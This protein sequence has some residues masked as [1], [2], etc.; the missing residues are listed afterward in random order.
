MSGKAALPVSSAQGAI[1]IGR[2]SRPLGRRKAIGASIALRR[3]I[4]MRAPRRSDAAPTRKNRS[5]V[6]EDAAAPAAGPFDR[7]QT[8]RATLRLQ[9]PPPPLT[10]GVWNARASLQSR[11]WPQRGR[12][13]R[14]SRTVRRRPH[15][16]CLNRRR[17][18]ARYAPS[19]HRAS[20]T[21]AYA[22][23]VNRVWTS[24]WMQ[25]FFPR[26]QPCRG[27]RKKRAYLG[28]RL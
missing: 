22:I 27:K 15:H 14:R 4:V 16:R 18:R 5:W 26:V 11:Q 2:A 24:R 17:R 23:S 6:S 10:C 20:E 28:S 25:V 9:T 7:R 3:C 12:N 1:C 21:R 8:A 19:G 13:D